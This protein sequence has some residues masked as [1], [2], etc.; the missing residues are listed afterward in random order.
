[1]RSHPIPRSSNNGKNHLP[2]K[3]KN[4][5]NSNKEEEKEEE[6]ECDMEDWLISLTWREAILNA[7]HQEKRGSAE[8]GQ[9]DGQGQVGALTAARRPAGSDHPAGRGQHSGD[10]LDHSDL[11]QRQA[12]PSQMR[13]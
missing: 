10:E 6:E 2:T 3:K 1:M 13:R 11:G 9:E 5:M 7:G 8:G 12:Q 4:Q